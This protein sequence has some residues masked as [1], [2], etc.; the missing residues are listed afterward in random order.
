MEPAGLKEFNIQGSYSC[1]VRHSDKEGGKKQHYI[2]SEW[3]YD[4]NKRGIS[5][6]E[7]DFLS[8]FKA[9]FKGLTGDGRAGRPRRNGIPPLIEE[10]VGFPCAHLSLGNCLSTAV[11]VAVPLA[12]HRVP[13]EGYTKDSYLTDFFIMCMSCIIWYSFPKMP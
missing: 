13:T 4:G 8:I 5:E 10:D 9:T 1:G 2:S 3:Q 6:W 11:I 12:I 7:A